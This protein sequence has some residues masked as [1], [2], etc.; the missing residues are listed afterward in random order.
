VRICANVEEYLLF[1]KNSMKETSKPGGRVTRGGGEPGF[2][3][4]KTPVA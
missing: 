3:N 2:L 4:I 1:A